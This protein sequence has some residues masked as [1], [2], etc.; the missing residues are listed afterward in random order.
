MTCSVSLSKSGATRRLGPR[1]PASHIHW[2]IISGHQVYASH[3]AGSC[4]IRAE[5]DLVSV[6]PKLLFYE[7]GCKTP[8]IRRRPEQ[9]EFVSEGMGDEDRVRWRRECVG[10]DDLAGR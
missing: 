8:V 2:T 6:L 9:L 4:R 3:W 7:G 5:P 1:L 10:G